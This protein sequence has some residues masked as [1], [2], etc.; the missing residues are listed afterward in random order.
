MKM[1]KLLFL[2]LGLLLINCFP[3][4]IYAK[5]RDLETTRLKSTAGTGV[6]SILMEE[7][8][9]LNPAPVAFFKDSS[10]Y[11][12][13]ISGNITQETSNNPHAA[14]LDIDSMAAILTE[15]GQTISGSI[16]YQYAEDRFDKRKRLMIASAG[17]AGDKSSLGIAARITQDSLSEN[18]Q[19]VQ[20]IKY[21]QLVLGASHVLGEA[22][23]MGVTFIDPLKE[24]PN[25]TRGILG[26]QY[27]YED[28]VFLILDAGADYNKALAETF[29]YRGAVQFKVFGDFFVRAG[30]FTDDG[31]NENGSGAGLSWV[32]PKLMF[33]FALKNTNIKADLDKNI[34]PEKI[35]ETSFSLSYRF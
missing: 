10:I 8:S 25:E 13:K 20:N 29:L 30:F 4:P 34:E 18:G 5:L 9:V 19:D 24:R 23:T 28:F 3:P 11:L 14:P 31:L 33:D 15:S 22:V 6:G 7:S 21:N 2:L 27:V 35:K 32:Q 16:G 17:R 12:Q 1:T 26:L